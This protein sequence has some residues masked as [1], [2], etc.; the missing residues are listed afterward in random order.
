M[1]RDVMESAG[2]TIYAEIGLI[3]LFVTFLFALARTLTRKREYYDKLARIP[4]DDETSSDGAASAK[5]P[6]EV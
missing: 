3:L 5:E 6:S 1:M 4:F 2:L